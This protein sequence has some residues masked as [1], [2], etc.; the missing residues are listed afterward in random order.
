MNFTYPLGLLGLI[1][2]PILILIYIIKNKY[3]EQTVSS[4]YI[5]TLSEKFLKRRNPISKIAGIIS[6][7]L[8]ILAVILVSIAIAHPVFVI[9]D[10]AKEYCFILDG[11]GSM[12]VLYDGDT[13]FNK[14]V[15]EI[16]EVIDNSQDGSTYTLLFANNGCEAVYERIT[17]KEQAIKLLN[18]LKP[19][20][21]TTD[22]TDS[23]KRAQEYFDENPSVVTY[24]VTDGNY[25]VDNI[26]LLNLGKDF[27][28]YSLSNF[29]V[30]FDGEKV[31]VAGDITSYYQ[32][33]TLPIS[34]YVDGQ[35]V[36]LDESTVEV[37]KGEKKTV[38]YTHVTSEFASAKVAIDAEDDL[39]ED[40]V[41]EIFD[42]S[43]ENG[44][45][46]LIV[47]DTPFFL[48]SMLKATGN[49]KIKVVG[50]EEYKN[51]TGFSLYVFHS[52]VPETLPRDGAIW[53]V[54]ARQ[55][56]SGTGFS[57]QGVVDLEKPEELT[58]SKSTATMVKQ[59]I[60]GMKG[61]GIYVSSYVKCGLYDNFTTLLSYKGNPVVFTGVNSYGNREVVFAFDL[62]DTN[63]PLMLDFVALC[64]NLIDYTFPDVVESTSYYAG[65]TLNVNVI[66]NCDSI[67]VDTP[68]GEHA[69]L[70]TSNAIAEYLLKEV[71]TY[72]ITVMVGDAKSEF[73]ISSQLPIEERE[74]NLAT[75]GVK[76]VGQ[77]SSDGFDGIFDEL[78]VW[79]LVLG[80]VFIADWMVYCYEKYQLR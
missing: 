29:T 70:D 61:E 9:P 21:G 56:V 6:L 27:N 53:F 32:D 43:S 76:L 13:G 17:N 78:W 38:I 31:T 1:G 80:A 22:F 50:T 66:T 63:F 48:E 72:K 77:A 64:N 7:I 30:D 40:N 79:M 71:G 35:K 26:K 62:H 18:E 11:S 16:E 39:M 15:D 33:A 20:F 24:L 42:I 51:Y 65:D 44:F 67:R 68:S 25:E 47:S 10:A 60:K 14:G 2:I 12:N 74:T 52:F 5:W 36:D 34:L 55:S 3:T 58:L 41:V 73:S 46:T 37:K 49:A 59:L 8:Q 54:N 69:Y 57:V 28:N 45:S 19:G 4:T 23:I 75:Q